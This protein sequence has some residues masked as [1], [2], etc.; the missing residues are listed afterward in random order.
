[1]NSGQPSPQV[2]EFSGAVD[3]SSPPRPDGY[4]PLAVGI[5]VWAGIANFPRDKHQVE[6]HFMTTAARRLDLAHVMIERVRN[7]I[8]VHR[9]AWDPERWLTLLGDSE[10]SM[11]SL[12][13]AI[14]MANMARTQCGLKTKWPG[15]IDQLQDLVLGT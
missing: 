13:K 3:V 14:S 10:M 15:R 9:Q 4:Q 7:G 5:L 6:L 11:V 8:E 1:M 2:V 12:H